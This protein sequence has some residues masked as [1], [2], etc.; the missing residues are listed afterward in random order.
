MQRERRTLMYTFV[1]RQNSIRLATFITFTDCF[2]PRFALAGKPVSFEYLDDRYNKMFTS[3][4]EDFPDFGSQKK[5]VNTICPC[6]NDQSF[7][8]MQKNNKLSNNDI[9]ISKS[10]QI[11]AYWQAVPVPHNLTG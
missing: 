9:L 5:L 3:S 2:L 8:Y 11:F 7:K 10:K 4:L 1:Y 6:R